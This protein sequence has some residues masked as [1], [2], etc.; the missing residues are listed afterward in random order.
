MTNLYPPLLT[1]L[2]RLFLCFFFFALTISAT[3]AQ[4][5]PNAG[6]PSLKMAPNQALR[7]IGPELATLKAQQAARQNNAAA[8]LVAP[9]TNKSLLQVKG[10]Y[11]VIEAL[12]ENSTPQ[13]LAD[14]QALGMTQSASFG[15]MVSGVVPIA[16]LDKIAK[17]KSLRSARPAYKPISKIGKTTS[18]GAR[19]LYTDEARKQQVI[20]GKGSKVGI[21]S[22]SY[23]ALGGADQGVKSGDLP[24]KNNP[25]NFTTPVEVLLD[26]AA[27]FGSDEGRAMAEIVHDLAP[28]AEL[29]F[30]SANFGEASFAQ[31]ILDL[32]KAGC[33]VI[34]D[35][36]TYLAEPMFQDGII[37]QAVDSV[38]KAGASYFTA[39]G[40]NGR[41][42]YQAP[43]KSG[44]VAYFGSK[45][46]FGSQKVKNAHNFAPA[47]KKKDLTQ[48]IYVPLGATIIFAF[49][50][51]EPFYSV[52][53][54]ASEGAKTDLDIYLLT[55][56]TTDVVA[57]SVYAN[58]GSD[59]VE[60]MSFTND[61]S[62]D[63]NYFN[64][65]IDK[66]DGPAV[67][68]GT[69]KYVVF[70]DNND[71]SIEEYHTSSSTIYGHNNAAGAITTGAV[72]FM[73]TPAYGISTPV[74]ESFSSVGGTPI[75]FD[76]NG[77]SRSRLIRRKPEVMAPDGV[78][79]TFFGDSFLDEFYFFGTSAAAPHV[80]A[81]AALMQEANGN[82]LNADQIKTALQ[83]TALNMNEPG[84]DYE[85][86][87]GYINAQKAIARVAKP[88]IL[89]FVLI[90]ADS[91]QIIQVLHT[92]DVLNLTRLPSRN[93]YIQ[94][95]TGPAKIGSVLIDFND[96][97][98][99]EN[100]LPYVYPGAM[101]EFFKLTEGS[102]TLTA[103]PYSQ[104]KGQGNEG[105]PSTISF[106]AVEEK[107]V[108]FELY[109]VSDGNVIRELKENTELDLATLP[110]D[111][112]IRAVT[113]PVVVGSVQFDLNGNTT[114]ENI[115]TYD[116]AGSSG[117]SISF[118]PG[119]YTLTAGIYPYA[120]ARGQVG[121]SLTINF[122]VIN[123]T[124]RAQDAQLSVAPN[125]FAQQARLSFSVPTTDNASLII[126]NL[127]GKQ[128]AVLHNGE[129]VAGKQ[130]EYVLNG[131]SLPGGWY[132]SR[133][134][135]S[136]TSLHQKLRLVK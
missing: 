134:V 79:N 66:F 56:D 47:G 105:V 27:D 118:K 13:L 87:Y 86:G 124:V 3:K 90:D 19:A 32:Q 113:N 1:V 98:V 7:K 83:Q 37:A 45:S 127:N 73:D 76:K 71:I 123:S 114:V 92:G 108:R 80:A 128:V 49:Q 65:L 97:Q 122:R 41:E 38:K 14:L 5:S 77:K 29:A 112:N 62:Y 81:V 136:K 42:S 93:V 36:I 40:N 116:L 8:P 107:I 58:Q 57:S 78:N 102:Y 132:I 59:P 69:M 104:A 101:A 54:G 67:G 68:P 15:R 100:K 24:G 18:Q 2:N 17:L 23:N 12:S 110:A 125:P 33:N 74:A 119:D 21:I 64:L 106:R 9:R 111:L 34:T 95:R 109:H 48:K 16:N 130:Y 85:T 28:G 35:D 89:D 25:N 52:G 11:V 99:I 31:G 94:A 121:G 55:E 39:A 131:N 43:F 120:K 133:L 53:N 84:F 96:N 6:K 22:D 70:K 88:R 117:Q 72:F 10:N 103:V 115:N 135:T 50:Y 20:T 60:I 26:E 46:S 63:S 126:Y 91:R 51:S 30:Y 4:R 129:A 82:N 44:G 75:L 61:G